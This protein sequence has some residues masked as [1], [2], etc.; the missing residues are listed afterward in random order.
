MTSATTTLAARK[1]RVVLVGTGGTIAGRGAT[2][3]STSAYDCSVVPVDEVLANVPDVSRIA[4]VRAEQLFQLGSENFGGTH[5]IVLGKHVAALLARD[6]VDGIVITHGT[7]T[8]EETAFFLH[9]TLKSHKPVVLV[10][11]MRPPS[12]ISADGPI[13]LYHAIAVAASDVGCRKGVLLVANDEIH[14]ARDVV[15]TN[16][17]KLEA[18]ASPYGPLGYV[19]EGK[20]VFYRLPARRHTTG[21]EWSIGDIDALPEVGVIYAH[22][23]MTGSS[24]GALVE[25]G[26]KAVIYAGTGNG[27]VATSVVDHLRNARDRGVHVV[28]ASRTGS[29]VVI[30][31]AAQAD[32]Q[33]GWLVADDHVPQKARV[34]MMLALTRHTDTKMLQ[35]V[36]FDY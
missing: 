23:G 29:G 13:N 16:T 26:A 21:T 9:L 15:K 24:V 11:A 2:A 12:A 1:P 22:G 35:N 27:N 6:D 3:V 7:D 10:G 19:V 28:R 30:R 34:L 14:T 25:A 33:Y 32:D 5:L 31:N 4:E 18:F 8:I 36:F 20:P 17:F